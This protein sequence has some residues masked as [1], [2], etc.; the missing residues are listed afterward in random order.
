MPAVT[1]FEIPVTGTPRAPTSLATPFSLRIP[2]VAAD[3]ILNGDNIDLFTPPAGAIFS[4]IQFGHSATLGA[5]ATIQLRLGALA[6]T[7]ATTQG[8]ASRVQQNASVAPAD[9]V[10]KLN[11]LVGGAN[12]AAS[13]TIEVTGFYVLPN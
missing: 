10:Q 3:G 1:K 2:V 12:I 11:A 9:G 5:A 6:L 4:G 7:A 13:A 8:G